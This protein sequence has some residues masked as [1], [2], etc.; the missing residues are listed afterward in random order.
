MATEAWQCTK[1]LTEDNM[2][3]QWQCHSDVNPWLFSTFKMTD[4]IV[5]SDNTCQRFLSLLVSF[6]LLKRKPVWACIGGVLHRVT[7]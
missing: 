3:K 7:A 6:L 1:H 4:L 2:D 5:E